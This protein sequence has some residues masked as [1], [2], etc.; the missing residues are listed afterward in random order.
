MCDRCNDFKQ[1]MAP[2]VL[3]GVK[4]EGWGGLAR[5]A[6]LASVPQHK[7]PKKRR[8]RNQ[9]SVRRA[10]LRCHQS[11]SPLGPLQIS[12]GA[13]PNDIARCAVLRVCHF[14]YPQRRGD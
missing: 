14:R 12:A 8:P 4:L 11:T 7:P 5:N 10:C 6:M 9:S 13:R 1:S 3:D 2:L